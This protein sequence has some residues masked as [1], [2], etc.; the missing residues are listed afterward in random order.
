M[1]PVR[2]PLLTQ[3]IAVDL[4]LSQKARN[5][6]SSQMSEM[7]ETNKLLKTAVKNT[8]NKLTSIHHKRTSND[9]K[10]SKK[11]NKTVTFVDNSNKD[12]K[13]ANKTSK[14]KTVKTS[15]KKN[16]TSDTVSET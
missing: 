7:A 5:K 9:P 4:Q 11:V 13:D 16:T 8:Y 12:S 10:T 2:L 14:S 1:S 3:Q 15:N 6:L